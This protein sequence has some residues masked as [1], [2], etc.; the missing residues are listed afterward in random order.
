VADDVF[1]FDVTVELEE[2]PSFD[3][4]CGQAKKLAMEQVE[5]YREEYEKK[6]G[7]WISQDSMT[8]TFRSYAEEVSYRFESV[9]SY[10]FSVTVRLS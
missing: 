7:E 1:T 3:R 4:A 5:K 2:G 9:Y 10:V 6:S 8:I